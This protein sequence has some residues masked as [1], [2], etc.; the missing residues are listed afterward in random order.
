[1]FAT[2]FKS[3]V[4]IQKPNSLQ[5]ISSLVRPSREQKNKLESQLYKN[6]TIA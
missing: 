3:K 6:I 2:Y 4:L 1:M 5:R